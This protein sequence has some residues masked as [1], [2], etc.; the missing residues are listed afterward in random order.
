MSYNFSWCVTCLC[1][2]W[3]EILGF[4]TVRFEGDHLNDT[5]VGKCLMG[6]DAQCTSHEEKVYQCE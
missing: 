3:R 5:R 1:T 6:Q 2:L 4:N